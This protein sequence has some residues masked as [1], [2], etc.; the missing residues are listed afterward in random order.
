MQE[1]SMNILDIAQN[2]VSAMSQHITITVDCNK[3]DDIL[4][5]I[6][7][8]DGKGMNADT[9]KKVTDPFYTTRT[10]RK[11][12]LGVPFF[13]MTAEMTGGT[14]SIDSAEGEGTL[15]KA[16]F[17]YTHIDRPPLG[18]LAETICHLICLNE[19][20]LIKFVYRINDSEFIV[21]TG[22]F[23]SVLDGVALN[24]PQVMQ[25]IRGY[26]KENM[27]SLE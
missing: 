4:T 20:I 19:G 10:T 6:I 8:D 5:I 18:D 16:T 25:F 12:G 26:L 17:Q 27:D 13:K 22:E 21:E 7:E 1:L 3:N 9:L 2:S 23:T 14:F 15:I 24:T 11:V